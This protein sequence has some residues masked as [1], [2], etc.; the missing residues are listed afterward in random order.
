[1]GHFCL[2]DPDLD[3][4]Y[5][6]GSTVLIESGSETLLQTF[7]PLLTRK[8]KPITLSHRIS[9]THSHTLYSRRPAVAA[10]ASRPRLPPT[11][12]RRRRPLSFSGLLASGS[13]RPGSPDDWSATHSSSGWPLW[14]PEGGAGLWRTRSWWRQQWR[15]S[16][17][18]GGLVPCFPARGAPYRCA[19]GPCGT[20][21]ENGK[22]NWLATAI[23]W[24]LL[25]REGF[26]FLPCNN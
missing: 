22:S 7:V 15:G 19:W 1:M 3:S 20:A 26:F 21:P 8:T 6:S 12:R 13:R 2:L 5:G 24:T 17:A 9:S 23:I 25:C 18:R 11:P 14:R 16:R 10:Y 4:E